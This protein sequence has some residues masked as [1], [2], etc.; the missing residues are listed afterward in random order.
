MA[1]GPRGD[2]TKA[3]GPIGRLKCDLYQGAATTDAHKATTTKE[4]FL[5]RREDSRTGGVRRPLSL[6]SSGEHFVVPRQHLN[7]C[8]RELK[9]S[10]AAKASLSF[11][12]WRKY[13]PLPWSAR[14]T[15]PNSIYLTFLQSFKSGPSKPQIGSRD[16]FAVLG[17]EIFGRLRCSTFLHSS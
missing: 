6:A 9:A 3:I 14:L 5:L 10:A 4:S 13:F 8:R 2:P 16:G 12:R 15:P 7:C 1:G 11:A 17:T